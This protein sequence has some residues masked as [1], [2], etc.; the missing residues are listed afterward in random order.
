M[1]TPGRASFP[2]SFETKALPPYLA[3]LPTMRAH[4]HGLVY[5]DPA[6]LKG[7]ISVAQMMAAEMAPAQGAF[8]AR[9]RTAILDTAETGPVALVHAGA[10]FEVKRQVIVFRT[11]FLAR[12]DGLVPACEM[13]MSVAKIAATVLA[14]VGR[15]V[16]AP[17]KSAAHLAFGCCHPEPFRA[18]IQRSVPIVASASCRVN[19]GTTDRRRGLRR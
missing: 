13:G 11:A 15:G 3:P 16:V 8:E 1:Q 9:V 5:T 2:P 6:I 10:V 7:V 12:A 19:V 17:G 14:C 18:G 4:T